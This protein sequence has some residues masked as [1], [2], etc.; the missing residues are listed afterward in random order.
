MRRR[1]WRIVTTQLAIVLHVFF[2]DIVL[3]RLRRS[4]NTTRRWVKLAEQFR[5]LALDL[6]GV[7]IKM[8]Q[9]LSVR[10]DVLPSAVTAVLAE[11][12]DAV[13]PVPYAAIA[14]QLAAAWDGDPVEILDTTPV[15]AASL[16]QVYRGR[17]RDDGR[18]VAVKVLRPGIREIIETDLAAV[19]FVVRLIKDYPL[20]RRRVDMQRV[21]DE[22]ALVLRQEL[23]YRIEQQNNA[24]LAAVLRSDTRIALPTIHSELSSDSVLVMDWIDG[25]A[26]DNSAAL[27]AA[28]IDRAQVARTLLDIFFTQCFEHGMFHADPHPGNMVIVPQQG[29]K[30]TLFLLDL[31]AVA[32]VSARLQR[33]LRRGIIAVAANDVV[34]TVD[35]LD[36]MGMLTDDADHAA[37]RLAIARVLEEVFDR[38][39]VELRD[40]DVVSLSYELR[41]VF[42]A[43]PFQLPQDVIYL[44][45]ALSLLSGVIGI[46][47][48]QIKYLEAMQP[49]ARRWLAQSQGTLLDTAIRVGRQLLG[50]PGRLDRV[51]L[52]LEHG[53]LRVDMRSM[54]RYLQRMEQRAARTERIVLL[55]LL[56]GAAYGAWQ[57]WGG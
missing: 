34:G 15:A 33:Q 13:P 5:T 20:I 28:G 6:G 10:V 54:E 38:S 9:F 51:L 30:W 45:R 17:R 46:L 11:L 22:F 44:G 57:Y 49:I 21:Y 35:A 50:V 27:D 1:F 24:R 37:V 32:T 36:A 53:D 39:V 52:S 43:L 8:G 48:P 55:A 41:D 3:G 31:G 25:I 4:A 47:D 40:I 23:D 29:G 56:V 18:L 7:P 42:L 26:P 19:Q 14:P 16:G 2:Y 12:R